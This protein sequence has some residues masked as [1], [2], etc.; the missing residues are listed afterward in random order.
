MNAQI[1]DLFEENKK[2]KKINDEK[3]HQIERA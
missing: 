2:Y 1:N 3:T